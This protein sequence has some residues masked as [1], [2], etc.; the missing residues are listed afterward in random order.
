LAQASTSRLECTPIALKHPAARR[1]AARTIVL[2]A[3][4]A[5]L[6]LG[7]RLRS[8]K[9]CELEGQGIAADITTSPTSVSSAGGEW[10][11]SGAGKVKVANVACPVSTSAGLPPADTTI[12]NG[13]ASDVKDVTCAGECCISYCC[14][15]GDCF[16]TLQVRNTTAKKQVENATAKKAAAGKNAICLVSELYVAPSSDAGG[17]GGQGAWEEVTGAEGECIS[18]TSGVAMK[19]CGT[20]E[21]TAYSSPGCSSKV[22]TVSHGTNKTAADCAEVTG[23]IVSVK[24]SCTAGNR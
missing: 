1:M 24:F 19:L 6:C 4:L 8:A 7:A 14:G 21:A 20:G 5:P 23:N 15:T 10:K 13:G 22:G 16:S 18:T 2:L 12:T 3:L 11:F 17:S 9:S